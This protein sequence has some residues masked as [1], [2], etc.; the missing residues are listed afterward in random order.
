LGNEI[1]KEKEGRKEGRRVGELRCGGRKCV[2]D[3]LRGNVLFC[4]D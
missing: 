1:Y 4:F 3:K 2:S